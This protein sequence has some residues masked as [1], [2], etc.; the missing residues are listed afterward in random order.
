MLDGGGVPPAS[1]IQTENLFGASS[2][3]FV[4]LYRHFGRE[5]IAPAFALA[6]A[7]AVA[8]PIT[9]FQKKKMHLASFAVPYTLQCTLLTKGAGPPETLAPN[10]K[11]FQDFGF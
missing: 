6:P 10:L 2:C 1:S 7:L 4:Y 3:F 11:T 8:T 5:D 9:Q